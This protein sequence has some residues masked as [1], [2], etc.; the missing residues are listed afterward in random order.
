MDVSHDTNQDAAGVVLNILNGRSFR[1]GPGYREW[2]F[3]RDIH[4]ILNGLWGILNRVRSGGVLN[5]MNGRYSGPLLK[6]ATLARF[7]YFH[8]ISGKSR[9]AHHFSPMPYLE[10]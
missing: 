8:K 1:R 3:V 6:F 10:P 2:A 4:D 7:G 9:G 5:I